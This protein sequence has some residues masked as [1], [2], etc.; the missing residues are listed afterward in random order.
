MEERRGGGTLAGGCPVE[1]PKVSI[2]SFLCQFPHS[3]SLRDPTWQ[4][5]TTPKPTIWSLAM[6]S[7]RS[8]RFL[9]PRSGWSPLF[10]R[11][12]FLP[13]LFLTTT[14]R[15]DARSPARGN[16]ELGLPLPTAILQC[17]EG[18]PFGPLFLSLILFAE[19]G[20]QSRREGCRDHSGDP[21]HR[22]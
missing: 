6:T 9:S 18:D 21:Q 19:E 3:I 22:Q 8:N 17:H 7:T 15:S 2:L 13:P 16:G 14:G 1:D 5:S 4:R 10:R 20:L 11:S 12:L